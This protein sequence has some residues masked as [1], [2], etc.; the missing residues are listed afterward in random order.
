MKDLF[1][2]THQQRQAV[3]KN[4][5]LTNEQKQAQLSQIRQASKAQLATILTPEQLEKFQQMFKA[6]RHGKQG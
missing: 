3:L 6:R 2:S 1:Q 4:S 5:S